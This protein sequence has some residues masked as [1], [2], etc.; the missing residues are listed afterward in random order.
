MFFGFCCNHFFIS[1]YLIRTCWKKLFNILKFLKIW[2]L[3]CWSLF[4]S[5]DWWSNNANPQIKTNKF[6]AANVKIKKLL[7]NIFKSFWVSIYVKNDQENPKNNL[8]LIKT[9]VVKV[10]VITLLYVHFLRIFNPMLNPSTT[11]PFKPF[12]GNVLTF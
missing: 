3:F 2:H 7:N 4:F 11:L 10:H 8:Y 5:A 1:T 6:S 9:I 12:F